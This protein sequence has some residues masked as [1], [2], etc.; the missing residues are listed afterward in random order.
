MPTDVVASFQF[1]LGADSKSAAKPLLADLAEVKADGKDTVIFT[2]ANG[3][4]DFP[5]VVYDFHLPVMPACGR[6]GRLAI[7]N[8][9]RSL[10]QFELRTRRAV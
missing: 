1:H 5:F 7:R 3:N 6:Q 8:R 2:L 9:N 10:C 4:S